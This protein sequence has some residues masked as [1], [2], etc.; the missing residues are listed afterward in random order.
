MNKKAFTLIEVLVSVFLIVIIGLTLIKISSQ[1]INTMQSVKTDFTY[2]FS[3]VIN[4]T[5]DFRDVNDYLNI[6][7]IPSYDYLVEKKT[8]HVS[9]SSFA[10]SDEFIVDYT[11]EKEIIKSDYDKQVFFRIK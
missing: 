1:N 2:L 5:N 10:L 4:S 3:T 9:S 11:L 6:K 8:K 7:D